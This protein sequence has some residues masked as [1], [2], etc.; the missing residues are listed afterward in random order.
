MT[1]AAFAAPFLERRHMI[2]VKNR[3][4]LFSNREQYIGTPY[5][6]NSEIRI[7]SIDRLQMGGVDIAELSFKLDLKYAKTNTP[8]TSLLDKQITDDKVYLTWTIVNSV[9][10]VTGPVFVNIRATDSTGTV[11]WSSYQAVVYV[12]EAINTPGSYTG[13]LTELEQLEKRIEEKT[14]TLDANE[15]ERQ[16]NEI[17]RQQNT[18]A[19]IARVDTATNRANTASEGAEAAMERANTAAVGVEEAT[20]RANVAASNTEQA[21]TN[22]TAAA[23]AANTAA[24]SV[25]AA[26]EAANTAATNANS[27]AQAADSAAI[28]ANT[29]AENA[30]NK[31]QAANTSAQAANTAATNANSKAQAA[32]SAATAATTAA[33]AANTAASEV[34]TAKD[35]ANTAAGVANTA[36]GN[37]D[38][39]AQ[40]ANA[41]ASAANTAAETANTAAIGA[42]TQGNYAKAQ[43]DY[44]KE[45]GDAAKIVAQGAV[46]QNGGDISNTVITTLDTIAG[47]FPVPAAGER[48][49]TFFGK[50]KKF[51]DDFKALKASLVVVGQII[52]TF[53]QTA[54]GTVADGRALKT[55]KDLIDTNSTSITELIGQ[56][57]MAS[58]ISN[59]QV[60]ATDKVPSSALVN[61]MQQAI[62]QNTN[63]IAKLNGDKVNLRPGYS[64][65]ELWYNREFPNV[66]YVYN[67]EDKKLYYTRLT[68]NS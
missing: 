40:A 28:A 37:A 48:G 19:A 11:K 15:G 66:L 42:N 26:K 41:A 20:N 33:R 36:A 50:V 34:N 29:A 65:F 9:L 1:G 12:E 60:N 23:A 32:D 43:G 3:E 59:V 8:D 49:K 57:L 64:Q 13:G 17:K 67:I 35:N 54:E 39:K 6:N 56:V 62:T 14:E 2:L 46:A 4:L 45:Q 27:K 7:F 31:A 10:Q 58:A 16:A 68:E 63:N 24:G 44:A 61:I 5:D 53:D 38:A 55:L 51:I 22:A 30:N 47:E 18:A 21:I 25:E 52:N